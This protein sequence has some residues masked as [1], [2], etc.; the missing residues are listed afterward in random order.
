VAPDGKPV[1][2]KATLARI[3][4]LVIP[5]AW[6][7]VWISTSANGHLQAT[8]R[9]ARGRKQYRYHPKWREVRDE[10]K[11]D[12]MS[13]FGYALPQVRERIERDASLPGLPRPKVLATVVQLMERTL[14]RVGNDEYART[15]KSYGLT[16]MRDSHVRVSGDGVKF[17]FRGKSGIAHEIGVRDRQLASIV[18]RCRDLPGFQLFQYVDDDGK[19]RDV[20]SNDVNEYLREITGEP[21][22]SKDFRTWAGTVLAVEALRDC[23]PCRTKKELQQNVVAAIDRVAGRLGNTRAV[24][25]KCYIHPAVLAAFEEGRLARAF[26]RRA[27]RGSRPPAGLG[28]AE[29][30]VL[31]LLSA[32]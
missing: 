18:K 30:A 26:A 31:R 3:K 15:N 2:D 8:G 29:V 11:F 9:D 23:G 17:I 10:T 16:T 27:G 19:P 5:P 1:R 7:D 24:C 22:T 25:R 21:F 32:R 12:R 4:S 28:E 6:T 14:I 20:E 13:T